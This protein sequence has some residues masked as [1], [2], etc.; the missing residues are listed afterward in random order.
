[1]AITSIPGRLRRRLAG[2]VRPS[3][4]GR[5]LALGLGLAAAVSPALTQTVANGPYYAVPSWSQK[6][7]CDTPATC[8]RFH[9]LA[10][11]DSGAVLDRETGLVWSRAPISTPFRN[12]AEAVNEC[13]QL[14][15][16]RR[17]GWRLPTLAELQ[18]L[19]EPVSPTL[20][21][22]SGHPFAVSASVLEFWSATTPAGRDDIAWGVDFRAGSLVLAAKGTTSPGFGIWCVRGG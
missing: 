10:N 11:W 15:T 2:A 12:W 20:A 1:M 14:F 5:L 7:A 21:L 19:I 22:P 4:V 9:V 6:L 8:T 18:S 16:G 13:P 17:R 3:R